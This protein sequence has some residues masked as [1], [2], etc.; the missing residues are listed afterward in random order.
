M[1]AELLSKLNAALQSLQACKDSGQSF[2]ENPTA[3]CVK[4]AMDAIGDLDSA[5]N[6]ASAWILRN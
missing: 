2:V 6:E 1:A 5:L 3:T 4:D